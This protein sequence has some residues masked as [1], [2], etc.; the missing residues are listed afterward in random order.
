MKA[1]ITKLEEDYKKQK[2]VEDAKKAN[3]AE[4]YWLVKTEYHV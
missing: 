4:T 2:R 3:K 1:K